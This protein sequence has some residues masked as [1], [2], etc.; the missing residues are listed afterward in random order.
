[1][2]VCERL[3]RILM[4]AIFCRAYA[5]A[6]MNCPQSIAH[7]SQCQGSRMETVVS[8]ESALP[9]NSLLLDQPRRLCMAGR[10]I[11]ANH[12]TFALD[13]GWWRVSD[14]YGVWNSPRA[15]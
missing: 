2:P 10:W 7:R 3:T 14:S 9:L 13:L 12:F 6:Y 5:L 1:M 8:C 15:G 11:W 4:Y